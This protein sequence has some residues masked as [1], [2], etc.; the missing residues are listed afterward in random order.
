MK[1]QLEKKRA[2]RSKKI[3]AEITNYLE[4]SNVNMNIPEIT[5][6]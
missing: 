3:K 2:A 1:M 4:N 5:E 6:S